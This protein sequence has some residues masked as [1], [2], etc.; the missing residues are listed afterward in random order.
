MWATGLLLSVLL[1]AAPAERAPNPHLEAAREAYGTLKYEKALAQLNRALAW[2][3]T[4]R[5]ERATI[6]LYIGLCRFPLGD[7]AGA[8]T[9]F[10]EALTLDDKVALPAMTSPKVARLFE[11]VAE[12]LRPAEGRP[13]L[14]AAAVASAQ[15][16]TEG[17]ASQG[18]PLGPP[19]EETR[20][21]QAAHRG[22]ALWPAYVATGVAAALVGTALVF[23]TDAR[24]T[25]RRAHEATFASDRA[26]LSDQAESQARTANILFGCGAGAAVGAAVLFVVPL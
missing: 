6:Y 10:R 4:Q 5:P 1:S 25:E 7:E 17:A 12:E 14:D 16:V 21:E 26:A 2:P 23:G 24:D 11:R 15:R 19:E 22:R 8:R 9:A 3:G 18:A 20:V 13:A